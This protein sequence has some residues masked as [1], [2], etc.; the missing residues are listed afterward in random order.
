MW[1]KKKMRK[2][3]KQEHFTFKLYRILNFTFL[4]TI[5]IVS[6]YMT[7]YQKI[8][9]WKGKIPKN[10]LYK[11]STGK[12]QYKKDRPKRNR[13]THFYIK[14]LY[15]QAFYKISTSCNNN[16]FLK[17]ILLC[18][19]MSYVANFSFFSCTKQFFFR[20]FFIIEEKLFI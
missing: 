7:V 12:R 4:Y 11:W 2:I 19:F 8:E 1:Q 6:S 17:G 13:P 18:C 20:T 10:F 14:V 5:M 16:N 15:T 9:V 3:V